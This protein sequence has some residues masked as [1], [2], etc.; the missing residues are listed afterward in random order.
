MV[1]RFVAEPINTVS[2][3]S[4]VIF[5]ILGASHEMRQGSKRSYVMLHCTIIMVGLGS[6]LFH[7]TLTSWGQQLDELPMV[8]HLLTA[9]YCLN[10]ESYGCAKEKGILTGLLAAY[11]VIFSIG[12]LILKTTTT[13][14]VHFGVLIAFALSLMYKRFSKVDAGN[15]GQQIIALFSISGVLAFACW[16]LDY[17]GCSYVSQLPLNPHGHM[18][19]HIGMGYSAYCS[20][21]MLKIFESAEA[22]KML[23]VK[24]W[25]GLP[26]A[27]RAAG[28]YDVENGSDNRQIF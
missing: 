18:W 20:V 23:D 13:F 27:Y 26:F 14:Q 22:G 16:L 17:H 12:H 11:A 2:N 4:F 19:W 5:G 21:V 7:G 24:F 1:T 8:W 6:M 25:C 10:R 28:L 3:L 15:N 9:L